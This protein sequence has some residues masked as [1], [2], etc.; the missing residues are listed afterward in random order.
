MIRKNIKNNDKKLDIFMSMMQK[1]PQFL[2]LKWI[3]YELW[4]LM[5]ILD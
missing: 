1:F 4:K 5:N 2:E 3:K